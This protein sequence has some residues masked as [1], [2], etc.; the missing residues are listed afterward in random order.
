MKRVRFVEPARVEFLEAV[1]WY[2]E[3]SEGAGVRFVDAVQEAAALALSY[4][5]AGTTGP[6]GTRR[7][8]VRRFP[9]ALVYR[10]V[11]DGIVV[12]AVAHQAR[13]PG[14]WSPRTE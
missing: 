11:P 7:W 10:A 5:S 12:F 2:S 1:A 3:R 6:S 8:L 4:P 13:A 9:F 14:Y